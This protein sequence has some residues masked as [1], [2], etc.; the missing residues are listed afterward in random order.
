MVGSLHLFLITPLHVLKYP[1]G[2]YYGKFQ[3]VKIA[4]DL[5]SPHTS[6]PPKS[7]WLG[8]WTSISLS[9]TEQS[10]ERNFGGVHAFTLYLSPEPI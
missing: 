5:I 7:S 4:I 3:D 8:S 9:V 2:K 1:H 6:L 10:S